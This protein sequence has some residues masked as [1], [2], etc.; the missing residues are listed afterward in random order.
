[1]GL[2]R[3]TSTPA[4]LAACSVA[5]IMAAACPAKAQTCPAQPPTQTIKIFNDSNSNGAKGVWIFAELEVGIEG[6]AKGNI[7]MQAICKVPNRDIP[8]LTYRRTVTNRFYINPTKGIAPGESVEITV[9]LFTQLVTTVDP[10]QPNQYAE[11]WQGQNLQLFTS[12]TATAPRAYTQDYDGTAREGQTPLTSELGA[13][14]VFPTCSKDC[15]LVFKKDTKGTLPKNGPSQL[16]EAT[17]GARQ[18]LGTTDPDKPPNALDVGDVDFDVSYVNYAYTGAAMG[19]YQ[20]DQVG[21]V[22]TPLLPGPFTDIIIQFEKAFSGWPQFVVTYV[23]GEPKTE[24]IQKLPSPLEVLPRLVNAS[25]PPDLTPIPSSGKWPTNV[26]P[27]IQALRDNFNKYTTAPNCVH[28]V[29]GDTF[30][31]ALLD[32]NT[33][34]LANY[35]KYLNSV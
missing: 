31:D 11:W 2:R 34:I 8:T 17:M 16:L 14:A 21:Y 20:N 30:C 26:W 10:T 12:A 9:P 33:L 35:S 22:G 18:D 19:P 13:K 3:G 27:P 7:W 25:P 6:P 1:M 29:T 28:S 5:A 15:V 32:V 4:L 23:K 24:T